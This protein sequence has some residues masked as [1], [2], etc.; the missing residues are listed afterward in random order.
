MNFSHM[1]S[2]ELHVKLLL[3]ILKNFMFE[4]FLSRKVKCTILPSGNEKLQLSQKRM[5]Q[6]ELKF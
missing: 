5:E 4:D 6:N 3:V 2:P 1:F